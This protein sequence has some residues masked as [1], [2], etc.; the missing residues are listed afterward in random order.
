VS[1]P[2]RSAYCQTRLLKEDSYNNCK[3]DGLPV[4]IW[5]AT[6]I[7]VSSSSIVI[8]SGSIVCNDSEMNDVVAVPSSWHSV[9]SHNGETE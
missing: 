1:A 7:N 6:S 8:F 4:Y 2:A 5:I 3:F 9:E